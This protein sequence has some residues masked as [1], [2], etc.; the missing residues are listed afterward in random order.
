MQQQDT[1]ETLRD[2]FERNLALYPDKTAYYYEDVEVSFR[3]FAKPVFRLANGLAELGV[4]KQDRVAILAQNSPRYLEAYAACETAAFVLVPINYRLSS[5]EVD[6]ILK[7]SQPRVLLYEAEYAEIVEELKA[8]HPGIIGYVCIDGD[9]A[10][11]YE[12]FLE[13]ASPEPP[14]TRPTSQDLA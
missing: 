14:S 10:D 13:G 9:G 3:D 11:S 5:S 2:I 4:R 7:D 8:S 12:A 1:L 6:Y